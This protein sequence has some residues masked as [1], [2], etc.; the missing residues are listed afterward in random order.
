[1]PENEARRFRTTAREDARN[2]IGWLIDGVSADDGPMDEDGD[3]GI[4]V[5]PRDLFA[6]C[7]EMDHLFDVMVD[8][9]EHVYS[10]DSEHWKCACGKF[11]RRL[12]T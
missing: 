8:P 6:A 12:M 10:V 3:G 11:G 9:L 1:M 4:L 7:E 2:L 5:D